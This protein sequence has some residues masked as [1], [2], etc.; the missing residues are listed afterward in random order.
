VSNNVPESKAADGPGDSPNTP[1][2]WLSAHAVAPSNEESSAA[3]QIVDSNTE[4]ACSDF[5]DEATNYYGSGRTRSSILMDKSFLKAFAAKST[6]GDTTG[7]S[8]VVSESKSVPQHDPGKN[9]KDASEVCKNHEDPSE[10][11]GFQC[12][13]LIEPLE[14][15]CATTDIP[16]NSSSTSI[17]PSV[18][19]WTNAGLFGLEPSKPPVFGAQD[20]PRENSTP[21]CREPQ[22]VPSS[23]HTDFDCL[24][25]T[26][27][28]LVDGS[29]GNTSITSSFMGELVGIRP[30]SANS[31]SS[32][33]NQSA[34]IKPDPVHSQTD[35]PPSDCSSSFEH[36]EHTNSIG[37]KT[38]IS[39]LLESEG[40]AENGAGTYSST[41]I[42]ERNDMHM[43][44]ASSFSSIAQRFLANTLQR[45]TSPKYNDISDSARAN[46]VASAN[47]Q[48]ILNHAVDRSE[49]VFEDSQFE[50]NTENGTRE[51]QTLQSFLAVVTLRNHPRHL[52]I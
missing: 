21:G 15:R 45:R 49:T 30:G 25:P 16:A 51:L 17:G 24:K 38:S 48:S 41:N 43:V 20:G 37:K 6:P 50:K 40:N 19:L 28:A 27:S 46:T 47:D 29:N 23:Q 34:A 13:T 18:K 14:N 52:S 3:N 5:I 22:Q 10:V 39:E 44:S 11:S 2:P 1:G 31:N 42:D 7:N 12:G 8:C 32:G 9:H 33:A 35:G 4:D 26:E 36:N